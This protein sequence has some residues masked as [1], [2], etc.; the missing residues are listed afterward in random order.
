M[1]FVV[2]E[3]LQLLVCS[4]FTNNIF[5]TS[6]VIDKQ[7]CDSCLKVIMRVRVSQLPQKFKD[8]PQ[9]KFYG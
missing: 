3:S 5:V 9:A 7:L 6:T 8:Q 2:C 4:K 1:Q